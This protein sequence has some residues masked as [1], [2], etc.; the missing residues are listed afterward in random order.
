NP[1]DDHNCK[2]RSQQSQPPDYRHEEIRTRLARTWLWNLHR[3]YH[4]W[5]FQGVRFLSCNGIHGFRKEGTEF[6]PAILPG[7]SHCITFSASN[8]IRGRF[9]RHSR[10]PI[11]YLFRGKRAL[12]PTTCAPQDLPLPGRCRDSTVSQPDPCPKTPAPCRT[13]EK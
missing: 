2:L 10:K 5:L 13:G 8:P 11:A 4:R 12:V 9:D 7:F 3:N 6:R 1:D